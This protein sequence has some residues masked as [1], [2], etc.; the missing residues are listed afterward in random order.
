MKNV[1]LNDQHL[2]LGAKMA[3][4]A[5]YNMPLQYSSAKNEIL[6]VRNKAGV[7]DVSHMG[8]FFVTGE[9]TSKFIDYVITNNY[10]DLPI[11]KAIYSP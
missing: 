10:L 11:G 5:G 4:F 1:P 8:E 9:D 6:S 3:P 7:F 2:S